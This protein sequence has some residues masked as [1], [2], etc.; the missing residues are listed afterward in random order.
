MSK[1]AVILIS[2]A[3]A[4]L[5]AAACGNPLKQRINAGSKQ[6]AEA[7][8]RFNQIRKEVEGDLQKES[9]LFRSAGVTA[10]WRDRF[11]TDQEKL[12]DASADL[13][14]LNHRAEATLFNDV[15]RLRNAA[16]ADAV[17]I[18]TEA[19]QWLD[20]KRNTARHLERMKDD[21]GKV[22]LS[23][24]SSLSAAIAKAETDWP[25]K[26]NDLDTRLL[27]LKSAPTEADAAWKDAQAAAGKP[28]YAALMTDERKL[29]ALAALPDTDRKLVGQLYDSWDKVL[30]NLEGPHGADPAC[31]EKVKVI[32]THFTDVKNNQSQTDSTENWVE[33][34]ESTYA[35]LQNDVGMDIEHKPA[36]A[37]DNEIER[38]PQ[39][40][41]FAYMA[42]PGQSNQYGHWEQ[43][44]GNSVWTWL[45]QYLILRELLWNHQPYYPVPAYDYQGYYSARRSGTT[46]YGRDEQVQSAPKYGTHGTFTTGRYSDSRYQQQGGTYRDSQY[47]N[48]TGGYRSSPYAS[49][50]SSGYSSSQQGHQ[51]GRAP[52]SAPPS[53]AGRSFGGG[54]SGH[55]FGSSGG[56]LR[57]VPSG[58][59]FG[60]R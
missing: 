48:S 35:S 25:A 50:P 13:E 5:G 28:D 36:G 57:S 20:L 49:E 22:R 29:D 15:D 8:V 4:I 24:S 11:E 46:Y 19:N 32:T 12:N 44:E 31:R 1:R 26:K 30:V 58:R 6:V 52:S 3:F 16:L 27:A 45:P 7:K 39:P 47:K 53:S 33:I 17:S 10:A 34:P 23:D 51:F 42:P 38:V 14:R 37:Y 60:R 55:R 56:G 54:S 2:T 40:P 21:D 9:D 41:G 18:Q 43:R 59:R